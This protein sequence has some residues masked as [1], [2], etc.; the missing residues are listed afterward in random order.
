MTETLRVGVIVAPHG[1]KGEAKVF[2]TTDDAKR[3]NDLATVFLETD[4]KML[5]L[6]IRTVRYSGKFVILKF[7]E[8][9]RIEDVEKHKAKYL[10][11]D[12]KD[13]VKLADDEYFISDL[14]GIRVESDD[15][16]HLG[17]VCDVIRTGANDVYLV[18]KDDK[19][20]LLPAIKDCVLSVDME[21]Q[22]MRVHVMDG[23]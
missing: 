20:M 3:F 7:A 1:L 16:E 21:K 17:T 13:A 9:E 12:K 5:P 10:V 19:D 8:F 2:P 18:R 6:T 14:L 23:L 11:I 4:A 15:G 22:L